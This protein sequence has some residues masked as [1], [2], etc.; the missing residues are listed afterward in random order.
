MLVMRKIVLAFAAVIIFLAACK[1]NDDLGTSR[2]LRPVI[3]KVHWF[4]KEMDCCRL[5]GDKGERNIYR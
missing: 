5:A 2:L 1:K 3:E 4:R